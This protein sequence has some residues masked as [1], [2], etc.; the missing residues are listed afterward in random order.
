MEKK[1]LKNKLYVA[2]EKALFFNWN[3]KNPK[4][5]RLYRR[6]SDRGVTNTRFRMTQSSN[7]K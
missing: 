2:A 3:V 5:F 1:Q 6:D 7:V 4:H